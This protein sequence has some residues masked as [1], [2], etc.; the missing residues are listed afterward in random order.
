M[1]RAEHSSSRLACWFLRELS[2]DAPGSASHL[3]KHNQRKTNQ[4]KNK[5]LKL[6]QSY[7]TNHLYQ[8]PNI[9]YYWM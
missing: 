4:I 9:R 5:K 3:L 8:T 1:R 6:T 2:L 7:Y